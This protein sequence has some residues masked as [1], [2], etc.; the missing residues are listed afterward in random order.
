MID[1]RVIKAASYFAAKKDIRSYLNGVW[2][3]SKD[4]V[5]T[6]VL[7]T[8]GGRMFAHTVEGIGR[9]VRLR[10]SG[11]TLA[12]VIASAYFHITDDLKVILPNDAILPFDLDPGN[13]PDWRRVV[14]RGVS[15]ESNIFPL[16]QMADVE[17]A[18]KALKVKPERYRIAFNGQSPS[19]ITHLDIPE[20]LIVQTGF[21][22]LKDLDIDYLGI[23]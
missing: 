4:G 18:F 20:M 9:P 1:S 2:I 8:D 17:K 13:Y 10:L 21:K 19:V 3:E 14:P 22:P 11:S 23:L 12:A 5:K 16:S 15:G 6:H 7:A